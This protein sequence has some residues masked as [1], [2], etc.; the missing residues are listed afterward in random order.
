MVEL[1]C[2]TVGRGVRIWVAEQRLDRGQ[3]GADVVDGA[4]LVLE[5]IETDLSIIVNCMS[6]EHTV[7]MEHFR[8]E[9]DFGALVG[10]VLSKFED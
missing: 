6:E 10:V 9:F 4:P 8:Y 2:G 5:N 7:R 1:G 3:D